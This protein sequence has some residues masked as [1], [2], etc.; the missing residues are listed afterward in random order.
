MKEK[1]IIFILPEDYTFSIPAILKFNKRYEHKI[2]GLIFIEGFFEIKKLISIL[3]LFNFTDHIKFLI[4]NIKKKEFNEISKIKNIFSNNI[5]SKKISVFIKKNRPDYLI[6]CGCNQILKKKIFKIPKIKTLNIH[7]SKLPKYRGVLPIFRAYQN[8]DKN[9]TVSIHEVNN[10]IDD[11]VIYN[12]K[13][14][15]IENK[16][17]L[18]DLYLKSFKYIP[19]IINSAITCNKKIKNNKKFGNYYSYPSLMELIKFR[20]RKFFY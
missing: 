4:K 18:I 1:K 14:I 16:D 10:K 2:V 17:K 15:K 7:S 6:I 13:T 11:G 9:F 8:N 5:N 12:R 20:I 19:S 3:F